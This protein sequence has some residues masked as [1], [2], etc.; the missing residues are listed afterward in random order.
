M[1]SR[2]PIDASALGLMLIFCL[3]LGL[4]QVVLKATGDD[5]SPVLQ[6]GLRSGLAAVL[7]ML[8]L[9]LH[10]AKTLTL[11]LK[12]YIGA[13]LTAGI[14]FALEYVL[15]GEALRFTTAAHTVVF[16]Y[17]SP[18]F[19]ALILHF[20]VPEERLAPLQWLGIAIA[21]AGI[22]TAFLMPE[23]AITDDSPNQLLGD[24]LAIG[25]GAAWGLTT[26][27]IRSSK[28]ASTPSEHT[29]L[30]QLLVGCVLLIIAAWLLGQ[31]HFKPTVPALASL[32]FQT[33]VVSFFALL[34]WFWLLRHY[35]ASRISVLSLLTP[36]FGVALGAVFLN[37]RIEP[38]FL[39]GTL[40]VLAGILLV[41]GHEWLRQLAGIRVKKSAALPLD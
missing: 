40:L 26:V 30:Y 28:L 3:C 38:E 16:L 33:V 9:W 20:L 10:P 19:A 14:L 34:I 39:L 1:N 31:W 23:S 17:T 6:I 11:P 4:Q 13:G 8:Y 29:L 7:V 36:L 2:R 27:V 21:L 18:V 24:L 32:T 25:G 35:P 41:S 37:E 22:A 5:I 12:G 15:A